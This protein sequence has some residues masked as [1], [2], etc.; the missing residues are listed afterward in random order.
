MN[1]VNRMIET[2][3]LK[4]S[5]ITRNFKERFAI[6]GTSFRTSIRENDDT[7]AYDN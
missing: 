7:M 4:S 1:N 5:K 2:E 6:S 3:Q